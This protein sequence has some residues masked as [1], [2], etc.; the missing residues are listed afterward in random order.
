MRGH[1]RQRG[2]SWEIRV[3]DGKDPDS[4][5]WLYRTRTVAGDRADAERELERFLD[6]VIP[7]GALLERWYR[8]TPTAEL[9]VSRAE[10]RRLI[11]YRLGA[12]AKLQPSTVRVVVEILAG[13]LAL[14]GSE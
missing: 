4:G 10:V 2:S 12:L 8:E 7:F 14:E 5:R 3:C 6:E 11:D 1:I 9:P 13:A